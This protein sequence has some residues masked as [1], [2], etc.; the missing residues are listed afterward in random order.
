MVWPRRRRSSSGRPNS[1]PILPAGPSAPWPQPR[2]SSGPVRRRR[3]C[4]CCLLAE[5]GP[6]DELQEARLELLRAR[7][8]FT[9][10][11]GSEA[12]PLLLSAARRLER[13]D[14]ALA[15]ETYL[16][17]ILA[18]MF[19]GGLAV[20]G[21]VQEAAEAARAAPSP[22]R[23]P[24]AADLLLDGLTARFADGFAA[25]VPQL[26]E[27]LRAFRSPDLSAEEGLRWLWLACTTA[28]HTWDQETWEVL[29]IRFVRLARDGGALTTLPVALN[30]RIAVH[31]L[32]GELPRPPRWW[33][34]W[35]RPPT[36]RPPVRFV[37]L[38]ALLLAAWRG[39]V[40]E[41]SML[42]EATTTASLQRGE[43]TGL[44]V[45]GWAQALISNSRCRYDDAL[46]AA[47]RARRVPA[48]HG[49][50][51]VG[52]AGRARRGRRPMRA[53]RVGARRP[54]APHRDDARQRHRVGVGIEARSRALRAAVLKPRVGTARRSTCSVAPGSAV[55]WPAAACSTGSGCGGRDAGG[56][57]VG[58]CATLTR[59]S[60]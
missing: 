47:Q 15:R 16:D 36:R 29:A 37:P 17:A 3:H 40:D 44:T 39:D 20:G 8:A 12:C 57:P 23:S 30:S 45:V 5:S 18:A 22:A 52:G 43:E 59:P 50:P 27:A 14:V 13:L 24:R 58:R 1:L 6:L 26:R 48:A 54:A 51:P 11:R 25:G 49:I 38:G 10:N 55:S 53:T 19:A 35:R 9:V 42:V 4:G 31:V 46:V 41:V 33:R 32:L 28:T 56:M 21:G 7:I 2:P 34:S 60:R